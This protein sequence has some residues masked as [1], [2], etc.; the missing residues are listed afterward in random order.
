ML[1][2]INATHLSSFY[3]EVFFYRTPNRSPL[4]DCIRLSSRNYHQRLFYWSSPTFENAK[5]MDNIST[6]D[7]K[8]RISYDVQVWNVSIS[9]RVHPSYFCLIFSMLI[10]AGEN[11]QKIRVIIL[12]RENRTF[13]KI[14]QQN[15]TNN[16]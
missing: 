5:A 1:L 2:Q 12:A 9:Y 10:Q 7:S 16:R 14:E 11:G 4:F 13:G 3:A 15:R 6:A 8:Q